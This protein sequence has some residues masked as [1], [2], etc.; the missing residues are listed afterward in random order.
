MSTATAHCFIAEE[1]EEEEG[2]EEE[3]EEEEAGSVR[4]E[5]CDEWLRSTKTQE[6]KAENAVA[7]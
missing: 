6:S 3:G 1:E 2:E 7:S 5:A 4:S